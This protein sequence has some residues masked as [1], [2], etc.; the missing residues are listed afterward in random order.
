MQCRQV[1]CTSSVRPA[2][3]EQPVLRQCCLSVVLQWAEC[4]LERELRS[5]C[6][7]IFV[8][9]PNMHY[10]GVCGHSS[11]A[12][13]NTSA[14]NRV[15][16]GKADLCAHFTYFTVQVCEH[17]LLISC[18][19]FNSHLITTTSLCRYFMCRVLF[20]KLNMFIIVYE[21]ERIEVSI[22]L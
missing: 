22:A 11:C 8:K 9:I 6:V 14:D 12:G 15:L 4:A 19:V 21:I 16:L 2:Q 7:V 3:T 5:V 13:R 1:F 20:L 10:S 17:V 18:L